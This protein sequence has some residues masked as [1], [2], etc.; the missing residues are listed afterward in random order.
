[1]VAYRTKSRV[2]DQCSIVNYQECLTFYLLCGYIFILKVINLGFGQVIYNQ[3]YELL[4]HRNLKF[5]N[6]TCILK[7]KGCCILIYLLY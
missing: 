6:K 2:T 3:Y 5:E 7:F 1:M 4:E